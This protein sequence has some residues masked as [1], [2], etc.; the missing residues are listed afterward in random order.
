VRA[1]ALSYALLLALAAPCAQAATPD[2]LATHAPLFTRRDIAYAGGAAAAIAVAA[3]HDAWARGQA[4]RA[5]DHASRD[6]ARFAEHLGNTA[7]VA[8]ALVVADLAARAAGHPA[9]GAATERVAVSVGVAGVGVLALKELFGRA[10]PFESPND[11][12]D[13]RPFSGHD[14]FPSGHATIAFAVAG[15]LGCE[16]SQ[17]W[18]PYVT[19]PAATVVAWSRLRDDK[20]WLSDVTAGAAF[21][22]WT[23]RKVEQVAKRRLPDGLWVLVYPGKGGASVRLGARF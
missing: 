13:F 8:P 18:L 11:S 2:S 12:R 4:T 16:S 21:G 6:A 9:F 10:R 23:A 14:A 20:H 3:S 7:V 1:A 15:A 19:Y 5:Q 17:R 22:W